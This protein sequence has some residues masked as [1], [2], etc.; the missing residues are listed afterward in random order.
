M[1]IAPYNVIDFFG[2]CTNYVYFPSVVIIILLQ[3]PPGGGTPIHKLYGDVLKNLAVHALKL[4]KSRF[5]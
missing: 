3:Y 5:I 4:K 2:F 1:T